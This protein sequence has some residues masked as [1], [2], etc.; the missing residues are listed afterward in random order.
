MTTEGGS[1]WSGQD[2]PGAGRSEGVCLVGAGGGEGRSAK[3]GPESRG[4][5]S[6]DDMLERRWAFSDTLGSSLLTEQST[7]IQA[8][9]G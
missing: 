5:T 1:E 4:K 8:G 3:T 9:L 6:G 2:R 7:L